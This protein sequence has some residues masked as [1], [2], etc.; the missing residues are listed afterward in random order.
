MNSPA[1]SSALISLQPSHLL[2][3]SNKPGHT[4][5]FRAR[6]LSNLTQRCSAAGSLEG[7]QKSSLALGEDVGVG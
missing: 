7:P 6:S 2:V 4:S 5:Y 3:R 1:D